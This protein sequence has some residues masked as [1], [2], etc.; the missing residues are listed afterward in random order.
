[1]DSPRI[2]KGL[3]LLPAWESCYNWV[4][5]YKLDNDTFLEQHA[6]RVKALSDADYKLFCRMV[7]PH[8][9]VLM[10]DLNTPIDTIGWGQSCSA[11]KH[12]R[13]VKALSDADYIEFM[14][15]ESPVWD[16]LM[17]NIAG[18]CGWRCAGWVG[19]AGVK[20]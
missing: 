20:P 11:S 18:R 17:D 2:Q 12:A 4:G 3:A 16:N 10:D 9:Q 13:M 8:H 6:Q 19:C 7:C 15:F 14:R 1:M 5:S